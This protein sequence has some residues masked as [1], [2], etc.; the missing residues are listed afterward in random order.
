MIINVF[1]TKVIFG[2]DSKVV[3][4]MDA[5]VKA[6]IIM[7][8]ANITE[9]QNTRDQLKR[10]GMDDIILFVKNYNGDPMKS[11]IRELLSHIK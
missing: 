6:S 3:A 7:L 9:L 2:K 5:K 1:G 8:D 10:V 11:T 4:A